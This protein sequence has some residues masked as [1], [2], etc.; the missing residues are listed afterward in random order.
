[1][2]THLQI[3]RTAG[4]KTYDTLPNF[5]VYLDF[6]SAKKSALEIHS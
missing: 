2:N 6:N 4:K 1:M 3:H 5:S